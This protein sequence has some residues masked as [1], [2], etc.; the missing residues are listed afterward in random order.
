LK[1]IVFSN[2]PI[3]F[4]KSSLASKLEGLSV[5]IVKLY[6]FEDAGS[7]LVPDNIK[8]IIGL[9]QLSS[10]GQVRA[11]K[12]LAKKY[13]KQYVMLVGKG[14]SWKMQLES[15]TSQQEKPPVASKSV[16]DEDLAGLQVDFREL[17]ET[18]AS[19]E[20]M[21]EALAK[22]WTGRP[23]TNHKQLSQYM[24]RMVQLGKTTSEFTSW[25]KTKNQKVPAPPPSCPAPSCPSPPPSRAEVE[26]EELNEMIRLYEEENN[27][28][29]SDIELLRAELEKPESQRLNP[30]E[31]IVQATEA[32]DKLVKLRILS[33]GDAYEKIIIYV[34]SLVTSPTS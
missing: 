14:S 27:Q 28:L 20:E 32:I 10:K 12:L 1:A 17:Y 34:K 15:I 2:F 26:N 16:A 5:E 7:R 3:K 33:K 31:E 6:R 8:L 29:K 4:F 9:T 24:L 30:T 19:D 25:F 21:V 18:D 13:N 11:V 23:L 22:Y